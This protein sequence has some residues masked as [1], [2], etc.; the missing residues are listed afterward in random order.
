M[1]ATAFWVLAVVAVACGYGVFAVNSMARA[2]FLLAL[3]FIAVGGALVTLNLDYLGIVSILMMIMEMSIM[4]VFM[5]AYM[6]NPGGLMPMSMTHNKWGSF[7]IAGATF[8]VLGIGSFAVSWP[9]RSGKPPRDPSFQLGMGIM[10]DKALVMVAVGALLFAT[11][12]S[13]VVLAAPRGRYDRY[14]DKLDR[15]RPHDPIRGGVGR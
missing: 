5:V 7:G 3:S 14:G 8:V 13:V 4:A 11:M 6:M 15:P 10:G 12:V 9:G 2:T 1:D